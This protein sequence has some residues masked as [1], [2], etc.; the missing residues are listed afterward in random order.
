MIRTYTGNRE[1]FIKAVQF[2]GDNVREVD[3][4]LEPQ[5]LTLQ[6]LAV[7]STLGAYLTIQ[8]GKVE[9]FIKING[10]VGVLPTGKILSL[11]FETFTYLFHGWKET[12]DDGAI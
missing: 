9:H 8:D 12:Y 10:F 7:N 5:R 2:T 4:F 6:D 3:E 1:A 11:D